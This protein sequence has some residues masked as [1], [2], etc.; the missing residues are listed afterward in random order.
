MKVG[1]YIHHHGNGHLHRFEAVRPHLCATTAF[2]SLQRPCSLTADEWVE[3]PMDA[4]CDASRCDPTAGGALHW[5]PLRHNGLRERMAR[6]AQWIVQS[7]PDAFVVD[8]SVEVA[9]LV[10]LMGV[11][12]IWMAQRGA[13]GD[14]AHRSAYAAASA[15]I[16][17]WTRSTQ[18]DEHGGA[19][20]A[21]TRYVGAVS[22]FDDH[23][24]STSPG[25]HRVFVVAGQGG[26]R[27]QMREV[28]RAAR[29]TAPKWNWTIEIGRGL[30][31]EAMWQHLMRADVV[32]STAGSNLIA[33]VAAARRPL[34]C[35]PQP[36]PFDEQ[37]CHAHTLNAVALAEGCER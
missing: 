16:A 4:P 33:E 7:R 20:P 30:D 19:M 35:L 29:A 13:R 17:P 36:R 34:I 14:A 5:A 37:L 18:R 2:S 15:I 6:I 9:L 23:R 3:L 31:S 8:V 12:V 24:V 10:R 26:D 28:H 11:P 27:L 21:K 25:E 1:W 32:V 22:R